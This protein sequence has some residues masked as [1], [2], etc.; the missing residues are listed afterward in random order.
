VSAERRGSIPG[1]E[2]DSGDDAEARRWA[3]EMRDA[4]EAG[5]VSDDA[6]VLA[7]RLAEE[8]SKKNQSQ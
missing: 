7:G 2:R 5:Q 1:V 8:K 6:E 4:L 3:R